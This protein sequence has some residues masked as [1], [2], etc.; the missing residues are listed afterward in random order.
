M[1]FETL[2]SRHA[3]VLERYV[4]Y[5]MPDDPDADDV[6]QNTMLA[7]L[8]HFDDL[9]DKSLFKRWILKI[10][11]NECRMCLRK[12][13]E[14]V[15]LEEAEILVTDDFTLTGDVETV[16]AAMPEEYAA[17]LRWFYLDGWDQRDIGA[18]LGIPIGTVKSRLHRA[19]SIFRELC[20]PEIRQTY[21]KG[22]AVM[23]YTKNFPEF[24]PNLSVERLDVPFFEV[25]SEEE[26]FAIARVG[27]SISEA[28]YRYP[29]KK[30][31]LVST[32]TAARAAR[33]HGADGVQ[34]VRDTYNCRAKKLYRNE[35]IW[36]TQLTEN[37][38]RDLGT[39]ILGEDEYPT[40]IFTFLEDDYDIAVNGED[41]VNGTPLLIRER[42]VTIH[43]DGSRTLEED[44]RRYT[45]GVWRVVIGDRAFECIK[46][47]WIRTH[48]YFTETYIDRAGRIVLLRW[49]ET[50]QSIEGC[51]NYPPAR[52]EKM[53]NNRRI[54]VNGEEF[55]HVE[56]R[57]SEYVL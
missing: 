29:D 13:R 1:E 7:A 34:I 24:M 25:K 14:T 9:R 20:P 39:L 49:Y 52:V 10:A 31:A 15:P 36:F 54:T 44:H 27:F 46:V 53:K 12:R 37:Y 51:D 26:G 2:L 21:L 28:T 8:T 33:I 55:I 6:L 19:K 41:R 23:N 43:D 11:E 3:V 17:L 45:D 35:S 50:M 5:R 4:R 56:D 42:P 16:L 57:F 47:D 22:D 48:T 38:R 18:H 30:L 40:E 32:C